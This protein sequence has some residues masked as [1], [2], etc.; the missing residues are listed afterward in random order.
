MSWGLVLRWKL[1]DGNKEGMTD[2]EVVQ[3]SPF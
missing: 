1:G 3:I 2:S